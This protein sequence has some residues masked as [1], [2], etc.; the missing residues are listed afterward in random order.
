MKRIATILSSSLGLV[1]LASATAA[2]GPVPNITSVPQRQADNPGN[3]VINGTTLGL[4]TEVRINNVPV[5]IVRVRADRIIVGPLAPQLPGFATVKAFAGNN[6][7]TDTLSLLP[8]LTAQRR[9]FVV[10]P[11]INNGDAGTY[12]LRYSYQADLVNVADFGI[13]GRR[14]LSPTATVIGAGILPDANPF[15]AMP[16]ALPIE[17]GLIGEDLKMQAECFS[18]TSGLTRYTNLAQVTGFGNPQ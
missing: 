16:F 17:I 2:Q 9:G 5:P 10:F 1:L 11:T 18:N 8:T 7:D 14:F 15:P 4:V 3:V 12:I 13:Y 6:T